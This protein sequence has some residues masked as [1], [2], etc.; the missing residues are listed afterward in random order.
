MLVSEFDYELPDE[1]IAQEPL[2]ERDRSRMLVVD[3]AG[4]VWRDSSFAEFPAFLNA[5]DVIVINNTRVFPARL[6][7]H[8]MVNGRRGAL[9]E[10]LLVRP[11]Q[12]DENS[13]N[14]WEVLAKPGRS[15]KAGAELEFGEG[16]LRGVVT[17]IVEEGRRNIRFESDGDFDRI[18]D[19]I[20]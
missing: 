20:G 15:L 3:R 6:I 11:V 8:R 1:L 19:E 13:A 17:A 5:G 2:A 14:E 9:V 18:V 16:R 4:Q 7:G 12:G 10:A